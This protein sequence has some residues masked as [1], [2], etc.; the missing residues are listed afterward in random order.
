MAQTG[1]GPLKIVLAKGRVEPV[2]TMMIDIA[3]PSE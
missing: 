1:L 2:G 3:S